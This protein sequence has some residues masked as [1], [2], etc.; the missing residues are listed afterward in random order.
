MLT[1]EGSSFVKGTCKSVLMLTLAV[2]ETFL[3][4]RMFKPKLRSA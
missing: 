1:E 4:V 3:L 2:R